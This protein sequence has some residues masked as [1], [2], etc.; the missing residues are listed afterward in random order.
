VNKTVDPTSTRA[1]WLATGCCLLSALC[2][3]GA[4][5]CLRHLAGLHTHPAWVICVKESVAVIVVGPWLLWQYFRG[6]RHAI[7]IRALGV[8]VAAG[9]AVQLAGN[10][11]LQWAL[12]VVG[13][14]VSMP[15]VFGVMMVAS[16]LFGVLFFREYL[17]GRSILAIGL[18]IAS[19]ALLGIGAGQN[20]ASD[21]SATASNL[22]LIVLGI[23]AGC[24][25][26][27]TYAFL[28][29]AIRYAAK[30]QV[31]VLVTVLIATAMG[32]LTLGAVSLVHLG[33]A[34]MLATE[35]EMFGWMIASGEFNL[36]A[37]ILITKGL[38]L[39]TLARANV[40]NAS[41]VAL[42]AT[43]GILLFDE[44]HNPW[45]IWGIALT[46]AAITLYAQPSAR[47]TEGGP[48]A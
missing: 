11:N 26:G 46:V 42:G 25:C 31:P 34:N 1:I 18:S 22:L 17:P 19:F 30:S 10:L 12:G 45:L 28:G 37:F 48:H 38:Q 40:L 44:R 23:A 33:P 35:P 13:L 47:K 3:T 39:T 43:A 27:I 4:N 8:L 5:I 6:I 41:Q 29:A 21:N 32:T 7:P 36:I 16:A 14:V 2:Y 20:Q 24:V 15:V 9:I